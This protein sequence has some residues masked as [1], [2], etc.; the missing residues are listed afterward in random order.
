MRKYI[1]RKQTHVDPFNEPARSL[2]VFNKTLDAWQHDLFSKYE[3]DEEIEVSGMD[4]IPFE[5][6][7]TV[8]H[9][10][11]LFFDPPFLKAFMEEARRLGQ[12]CRAAISVDD[13]TFTQARL[14]DITASFYRRGDLYYADLWY[15]PQGV[16]R[17]IAPLVIDLE[18]REVSYS[19]LPGG[20]EL[21]WWLPER[22]LCPVDT[23][24]HLFFVNIVF[25]IFSR[26]YRLEKQ[27]TGIGLQAALRSLIE[28]RSGSEPAS[29]I[30][31]GE[32]CTIE[33][34]VIFQGPLIIGDN[35]TIGPG[36][37][38]TQS[39]IGDNSTLA[40]GNHLHMSVIGEKCFL[41]WGASA[42]FTL[43]MERSSIDHNASVDMSVIG[44]DSYVGSGTV[45]GNHNLLAEPI[46]V[47]SEFKTVLL[48]L[49]ALG[50]CVGHN[51]QL[52]AGLIVYPGRTIESDVVLIPLPTRRVIMKDISYE[53]SDHHAVPSAIDRP[54]LYPRKKSSLDY[55]ESID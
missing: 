37:V 42:H 23:W 17:D 21:V 43:L 50:A 45:F 34:D 7:E 49:P 30:R 41:P 19:I 16:S 22:T 32:N 55:I 51:C 5:P 14:S 31:I 33:K 11:N 46:A 47:R 13:P 38:V 18:A 29:L 39:I 6:M 54:Q 3:I 12:P 10:D 24:V 20:Q 2:S 44:R 28:S 9:A 53:E 27:S 52:G 36:C 26:T 25:G 35:V 40:H 4:E 48:D 15:F 8:I 1:I